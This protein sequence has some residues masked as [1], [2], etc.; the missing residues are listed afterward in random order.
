MKKTMNNNSLLELVEKWEEVYKR[1]LLSFWLLLLLHEQSAY[2]RE[3]GEAIIEIS[4]GS[5]SADNNSIYRALSRFDEMGIVKSEFQQSNL[6]PPRKY[7]RLNENGKALLVEFIQRNIL[8]FENSA[9]KERIH[10][11]LNKENA[12]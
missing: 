6:G 11:V 8:I 10:A 4:L 2:P 9:V 3:I 12:R 5:M 1:G 7:Y